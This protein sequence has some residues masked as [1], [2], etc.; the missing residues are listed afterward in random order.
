VTIVDTRPLRHWLHHANSPH[1]I[2]CC[3]EHPDPS[4]W[5]RAIVDAGAEHVVVQLSSCI[6]AVSPAVLLELVAGGA[7]SITVALD[8]C[9]NHLDAEAVA[10]RATTFISALSR[11]ETID[12]ASA[13]PQDRKNDKAWPILGEGAPPVSRRVLLGGR[14][15]T[16][17]HEP[18]DHASERLV[19]VLLEL[20]DRN[21]PGT[22]LDDITT[23]IPRLTASRCAGGGVCVRICPVDALTLTQ[24]LLAEATPDEDAMTQFSLTFDTRRCTDCGQCLQVCP[25]SALERSGEYPWSSLLSSEQVTLRVGLIKRCARCG[26]P[27]GHFGDLCAVCSYRAAHPFGSTMPPGLLQEAP[28]ESG[29][30]DTLRAAV[31]PS[32]PGWMDKP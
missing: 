19:A 24:T 20:A 17:L 22:T 23:G 27:N 16:H 8:G 32:E 25:E 30:P 5:S 14:D 10:A 18:S 7:R 29:R 15:G 12:S 11:P 4:V 13:P 21:G 3:V 6:A 28:P 1:L 31:F 2:I 9:A 26:V